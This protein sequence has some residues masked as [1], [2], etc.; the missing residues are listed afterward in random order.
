MKTTPTCSD[1][2]KH[3]CENLD[4]ELHSPQCRAMKRHME[5]CSNC[6]TYL[7]SLKKTIGFYREYP[8]PRLTRASRKRLDTMLMMRINPRRAAKA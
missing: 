2:F 5:G 7:D 1:V 8:I 6:M 4:K 3:I